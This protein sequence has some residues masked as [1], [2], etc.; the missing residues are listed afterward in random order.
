MCGIAGVLDLRP[1]QAVSHKVLKQMADAIAHR[2]PDDEGLY[3]DRY[4]GLSHRR[5]AVID[6][7]PSGHQP[8]I[9]ADGRIAVCFN[10]TIY[11]FMELRALL[12]ARGHTFVSRCDTEVLVHGWEQWGEDLIEKLNGHFAFIIWDSQEERLFMVR[13]RF[14]TKPLYYGRVGNLWLFGSEIKAILAH[15]EFSADLNHEALCEYFTFQNLFRY[16]TLFKDVHLVPPA[17]VV[18]LNAKTGNFQRRAYWDYDYCFADP[19]LDARE[20]RDELKRLLIQAVRRQLISDVSLGAYLSGGL[21][22]GSIVSIA[23]RDLPRIHTFTCGWH[24]GGVEGV[25]SSFDERTEAEHMSYLFKTEHFEQVVGHNDVTWA[26]PKV[27]YHLEDLRLGMSYGHYYVARLASKFVKVCLGG[28]GGDELFGGYPWR[29]YRV[30]HSLGREEFIED[31]YNYWQRLVP[32]DDHRTFF[33][34]SVF[35][36]LQDN[37]MKQIFSRVFTFHPGL[38]YREPEDHIANSLYFESKTF[39]HSLFL[40]GDRLSMAN[41]LE[42]RSPFMDNDLVAFACKIPPRLK[43]RELDN[44]KR[45]DENVSAKKTLY[46]AQHDDGK[47]ILREALT[48]LLPA[49]VRS[50]AKQ[51]FSSPDESWYRGPNLQYVQDLVMSRKSLCHEFINREAIAETINQHCNGGVNFRLRIWSLLCFE[52]WLRIFLDRQ[53]NEVSH[54]IP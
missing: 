5:L 42:E 15:P 13:D 34:P 23:S 40:V 28:T 53:T 16:H 36:A 19:T 20:A 1:G 10:G 26:M 11:N 9:S 12:Q 3:V 14:G 29:Y 46:F 27:I 51:G 45:Q 48:E 4:L 39:L 41:G 2:G 44:W 6:P 35:N 21:D 31:Y 43:L 7:T 17:N 47:N 24:M 50:R 22:S 32:D 52:L 33:A 30:A 25:E 37:D 38:R 18:S 8:M 49:E 54:L